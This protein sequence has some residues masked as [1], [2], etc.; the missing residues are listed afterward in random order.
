MACFL[1]SI[2]FESCKSFLWAV[3]IRK[4]RKL[5]EQI[6]AHLLEMRGHNI[7]TRL[8]KKDMSSSY[9]YFHAFEDYL[10]AKYKPTIRVIFISSAIKTKF[11]CLILLDN[12]I[13]NTSSKKCWHPCTISQ[14][15]SQ[16][17][18]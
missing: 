11:T 13:Y 9:L 5:S 2:R 17:R 6:V 14:L 7:K 8:S 1:R 4:E 18:R 15:T 12:A 10:T 16:R 3:Y